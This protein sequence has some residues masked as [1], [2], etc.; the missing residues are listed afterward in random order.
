LNKTKEE[1]KKKKEEILEKKDNK[2]DSMFPDIM[3][4]PG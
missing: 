3:S 1:H 4:K 2:M